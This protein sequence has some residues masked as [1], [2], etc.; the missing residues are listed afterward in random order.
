V[1]TSS[2]QKTCRDCS[3]TVA[4]CSCLWWLCLWL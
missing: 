2:F 3:F 4:A 1:R